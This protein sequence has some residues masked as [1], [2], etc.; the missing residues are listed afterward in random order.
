MD[1]NGSD[2]AA[3]LRREMVERQI[4]ARGVTDPR[5]LAA[6][7]AVERHRFVPEATLEDAYADRPIGIG[8]EQT[9]SQP[10]IVAA[11]LERLRIRPGDRVLDVGTGSGYQA[12]LLAEL[13]A[14]VD[15]IEVIPE[16]FES[17]RVRLP[18]G[19]RCHLGD[20][21]LGWPERA[22]FDA[23][24]LAAAPAALPAPLLAQLAIGGRLIAPIGVDQQQL[25]LFTRSADGVRRESLY[26]VRFV[27]LTRP[28][29]SREDDSREWT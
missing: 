17:A 8:F 20:G 29:S 3:R 11:M 14:D 5:V 6:F 9:I 18:R 23:I 10:F 7:G 21:A 19:V 1:G 22:P 2:R 24:V 13:G 25:E 15:S 26:P 4:A 27:P 16:L 12:A 28:A